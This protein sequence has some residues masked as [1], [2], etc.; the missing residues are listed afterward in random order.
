M[1]DVEWSLL[2]RN[3]IRKYSHC[4]THLRDHCMIH[5]TGLLSKRSTL[6]IPSHTYLLVRRTHIQ[7]TE[8]N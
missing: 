7:L 8:F 1:E 5:S 3:L 4:F 2:L 6:L